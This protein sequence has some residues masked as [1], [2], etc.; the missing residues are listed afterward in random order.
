[1]TVRWIFT[2]TETDET[3]TLDLNPNEASPPE[4]GRNLKFA[5]GTYWGNDRMRVIDRPADTP[6]G[7]T[8]GGVIRTEAHYTQLLEWAGRDTVLR[9]DTH[10]GRGYEVIVQKFD[11]I[12]RRPT[13]NVAW[14]AKYTMTCL[15]L[16]EIVE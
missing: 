8:F 16:E 2:D 12:E 1:M 4:S 15:V 5:W 3:V 11:P 13:A 6:V 10:V 9:I 14:R 7:W